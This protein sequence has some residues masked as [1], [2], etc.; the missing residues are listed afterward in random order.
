MSLKEWDK[1]WR[2]VRHA[3]DDRQTQC[4]KHQASTKYICLN[5]FWRYSMKLCRF[6]WTAKFER[7]CKCMKL[8]HFTSFWKLLNFV[9]KKTADFYVIPVYI[10]YIVIRVGAKFALSVPFCSPDLLR[11]IQ[12]STATYSKRLWMGNGMIGPAVHLY[13]H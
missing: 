10:R 9:S 6:I 12:Q 2:W 5:H 7:H 1:V 4:V 13:H 11:K 3:A 8:I